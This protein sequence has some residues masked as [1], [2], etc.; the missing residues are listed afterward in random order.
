MKPLPSLSVIVV[1]VSVLSGCILSASPDMET[2]Y[3]K[4]GETIILTVKTFPAQTQCIWYVGDTVAPDIRGNSFE[5]A[6]TEEDDDI[7]ITVETSGLFGNGRQQ[8]N[9]V[10]D[11]EEKLF[12]EKMISFMETYNIPSVSACVI[13][14]EDNGIWN[15]AWKRA[16]GNRTLEPIPVS[17]N[18]NTVYPIGSVTKVFTSTAVMQLMEQGLIDL[19]ADVS[20]YLGFSLKNPGLA[21]GDPDNPIPPITIRQLLSHRSGLT[22]VSYDVFFLYSDLFNMEL[23]VFQNKESLRKFLEEKNAWKFLENSEPVYYQPGERFSYSNINYIILGYVIEAVT[24]ISWQNY[25]REN[26]LNPLGLND[27][28]YYW[29]EYPFDMQNRAY[30][31]VEKKYVEQ[32]GGDILV[33]GN[34]AVSDA[35]LNL[36][37]N[38][39]GPAGTIKSTIG[40]LACLMITRL[41]NGTG[42]KRDHNGDFL[43]DEDSLP[44]EVNILSSESIAAINRFD[45]PRLGTFIFSEN[46]AAVTGLFKRVGYGLGWYPAN[47]GGRFWNYPWNPVVDHE[48]GVDWEEL[49]KKGIMRNEIYQE[50]GKYKGGGLNIVGHGGDMPGYHSGMFRISDSLAII[51][52]LNEN[53]FFSKECRDEHLMHP[54][55]FMLYTTAHDGADEI[56]SYDPQNEIFINWALPHNV[57]KMSEL[58]YLLVQ[59]AASLK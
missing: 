12:A 59:K 10:C 34:P 20:D 23:C 57:V 7:R 50:D 47:L 22:R 29:S 35:S 18:V 14:K 15:I 31:Y 41:N 11:A 9:I 4:P 36:L 32:E 48:M 28:K 52:L 43:L 27:T 8:W 53:Y 21:Y 16:Y 39:A 2:V 42:Y 25:I 45:D 44:L 40:D 46:P 56:N 17:A 30:G 6:F 1:L 58:Q 55:K 3:T 33:P 24:N 26:I 54:E 37:Y 49:G 38:I 13:K 51:Y 19:D 5:Y